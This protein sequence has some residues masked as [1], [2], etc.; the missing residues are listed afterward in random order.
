MG[1][2]SLAHSQHAATLCLS[3]YLLTPICL[4]GGLLNASEEP[5]VNSHLDEWANIPFCFIHH[6]GCYLHITCGIMW[7]V[8][9]RRRLQILPTA[10]HFCHLQSESA[11]I[12]LCVVW[13]KWKK[14]LS[15][16]ENVNAAKCESGS[17]LYFS[18]ADSKWR[19]C[20]SPSSSP[21]TLFIDDRAWPACGPRHDGVKT[22]KV[23]SWK[24]RKKS[25]RWCLAWV[26]K[27]C[28]RKSGYKRMLHTSTCTHT[29]S[30]STQ[31]WKLS[32]QNWEHKAVLQQVAG[33]KGLFQ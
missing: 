23:C 17:G 30:Q 16:A 3:D 33:I 4:N 6:H 9:H 22:W 19:G 29:I 11:S 12:F 14:I 20:R 21:P 28:Q 31:L 7:G 8:K 32:A 26:K 15:L 1:L 24:R 5:K 18:L 10:K 25:I 13:K 27:E 2:K